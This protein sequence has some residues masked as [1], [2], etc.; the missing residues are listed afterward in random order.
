M[1]SDFCIPLQERGKMKVD[2]FAGYFY[3]RDLM[4]LEPRVL[5]HVKPC[6]ICGGQSGTGVGF[7]RILWLPSR[8]GLHQRQKRRV[9]TA[10]F[11]KR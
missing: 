4:P 10:A 6:G 11:L 9:A 7:L 5:P 3:S 1:G 8:S 2:A